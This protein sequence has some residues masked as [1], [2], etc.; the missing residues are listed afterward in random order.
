[1]GAYQAP[2]TQQ[3]LHDVE[4]RRLPHVIRTTLESQAKHPDF[5]STE[6]PECRTDFLE[7][8]LLLLLVDLFDFVQKSKT[9]AHLLRHM[10]EGGDIFRKARSAVTYAGAQKLR[11]DARI[12]ADAARNFFHVCPR[13]FTNIRD[14]V[15]E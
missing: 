5:L 15:D 10:P 9:H 2:F 7:E 13:C 14:N 4:R 12:H 1:M 11:A 6:G 3:L 8:P